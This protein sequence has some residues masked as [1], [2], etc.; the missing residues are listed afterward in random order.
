MALPWVHFGCPGCGGEGVPDAGT[1]LCCKRTQTG[2]KVKSLFQ[3]L[4]DTSREKFQT[5][6]GLV[7]LDEKQQYGGW[8]WN[9]RLSGRRVRPKSKNQEIL[10]GEEAKS[11]EVIAGNRASWEDLLESD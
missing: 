2:C 3:E 10:F 8:S 5:E 7:V 11:G 1:D 4:G 6:F 9:T